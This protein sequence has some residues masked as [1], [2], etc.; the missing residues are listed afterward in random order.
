M[1]EGIP[2]NNVIIKTKSNRTDGIKTGSSISKSAINAVSSKLQSELSGKNDLGSQAAGMGIKTVDATVQSFKA[3]Q[4]A[5]DVSLNGISGICKVGKGI[6]QVGLTGTLGVVTV[7]QTVSKLKEGQIKPLSPEAVR[8]LRSQALKTGLSNTELSR[9]L[10]YSAK[11]IHRK[12]KSAINTTVNI[13]HGI[14]TGY[15]I[16]RG[17]ISGKTTFKISKEAVKKFALK[18]ISKSMVAVNGSVYKLSKKLSKGSI[19]MISSAATSP[20]LGTGLSTGLKGGAGILQNSDDYALQGAGSALRGAELGIRTS[21]KGIKV[22]K[23]TVKTTIKT[24]KKVV[25]AGMFIKNNGLRAAWKAARGYGAKSAQNLLKAMF[26]VFKALGRKVIIPILI[27]ATVVMACSGVIT[28]PVTAVASIFGSFFSTKDTKKDFDIKDFLNTSVPGLITEFQDDLAGKMEESRAKYDIVRF[29]SNISADETVSP[30]KDGII[31]VFPSNDEVINM[32]Q[33]VF[34]A[35]ILMEYDLEPTEKQA[36]DLVE[37]IFAKLF[38]VSTAKTTEYCGQD[39]LTGKG[40]VL[41]SHTCGEIHAKNDCPNKKTGTHKSY[42]CDNCCT[43][44]CPGHAADDGTTTYCPGCT[45]TCSGYTYCGSH[46]VM[47]YTLSVEGV[48]ALENIYFKEPMEKLLNKENRTDEEET[49]LAQLKDYHEIF[50][51]MMNDA[52][53]IYDS[54]KTMADLSGVKFKDN[55]KRKKNQ[56]VVDLALSQLGQKGGQPYWSFLGYKGR[57]EWCACFVNWCMRKIPSATKNYPVLANVGN[58]S[59]INVS[60]YF[61][62]HNQWAD[63]NYTDLVAGDVIFFDYNN[64]KETHHIGIV[65]GVDDKKV[66]T[67]EGNTVGDVVASSSYPL[68]SKVIYGYGLMN[69]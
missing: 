44:S 8:T 41:A 61:K 2:S 19:Q 63:R 15:K 30:T 58:A 20:L 69:Y 64:Q 24:G 42:T 17:V 13:G 11:N 32:I 5:S 47:T 22:S 66:Y 40:T 56:K 16:V 52:T 36:R 4:M 54:G 1:A 21:I 6:Y 18:A 14:K 33:P 49:K 3:A 55:N 9:R 26:N 60:N 25:H 35:V 45:N 10:M 27:I 51:E 38:S 37:K 46:S 50:K 68:G 12:V 65:I 28:V 57:V 62:S 48:Y 67:V 23:Y 39:L 34:N 59:C 43:M 31:S 7:A 53:V 29:K